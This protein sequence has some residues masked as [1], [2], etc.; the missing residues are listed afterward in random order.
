MR[1]RVDSDACKLFRYLNNFA[2]KTQKPAFERVLV[3]FGDPEKF[4]RNVFWLVRVE[5]LT[6]SLSLKFNYHS[7][8]WDLGLNKEKDIKNE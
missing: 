1:E 7:F 5:Y 8:L 2:I 6:F 4:L 3:F